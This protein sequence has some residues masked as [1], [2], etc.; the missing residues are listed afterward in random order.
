MAAGNLTACP[1]DV[2]IAT[3]ALRGYLLPNYSAL[4]VMLR[5]PSGTTT[6][7]GKQWAARGPTRAMLL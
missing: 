6:P 1:E 7:A 5:P 4:R 3:L 2:C